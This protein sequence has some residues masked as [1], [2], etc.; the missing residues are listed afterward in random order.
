MMKKAGIALALLILLLGGALFWLH[1]NL[2]HLVKNA[3]ES[4]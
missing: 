2:N 3:I 1:H 4:Y